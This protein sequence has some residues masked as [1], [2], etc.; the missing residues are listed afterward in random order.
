M[1]ATADFSDLSA[2]RAHYRSQRQALLQHM[3]ACAVPAAAAGL[4]RA[5]A[6]LAQLAD[7]TLAALWQRARLP[8]AL[9]AVGGFGRGELFPF[10]DVDVLLL[11]PDGTDESGSLVAAVSDFVA[12]CWDVGLEISHSTR[13]VAQCMAAAQG[14]ITACTAMLEARLIAGD[15]ALFAR[16]EAAFRAQLDPLAFLQAKL[17]EQ[18]QRHARQ[19]N[20]PYAL[21]PNI[22]LL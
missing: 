3:D 16:F 20:T 11:W 17:M 22:L 15:A 2:I 18:R 14:D 21:E 8:G 10:S 12:A 5:L 19:Q 7:E 13:A 1:T 6:Q 4:P 9:V